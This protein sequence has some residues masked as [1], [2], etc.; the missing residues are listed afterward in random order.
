M[1]Q[2]EKKGTRKVGPGEHISHSQG[3]DDA[4][5]D[6]LANTGWPPGE[7]DDVQVTFTANVTVENPGQIVEYLVT[8]SAG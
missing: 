5:A 1:A 2:H 6:A 8:L 3:W 4:L 7:Y